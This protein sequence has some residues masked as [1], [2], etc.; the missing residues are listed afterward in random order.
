MDMVDNKPKETETAPASVPAPVAN[1]PEAAAAPA[2][3]AEPV[4]APAP[5]PAPVAAATPAAAPAPAP[6]EIFKGIVPQTKPNAP[7]GWNRF[8]G[9][10]P[11]DAKNKKNDRRDSKGRR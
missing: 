6:V 3:A 4:A 10:K 7:G 11:G 8:A 9:Y 2:V 5:V 1:T